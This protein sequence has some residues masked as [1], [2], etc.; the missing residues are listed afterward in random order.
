M[1]V[2]VHS[3]ALQ[4]SSPAPSSLPPS[5]AGTLGTVARGAGTSGATIPGQPMT[6]TESALAALGP[7][8]S[9]AAQPEGHPL[10]LADRAALIERWSAAYGVQPPGRVHTELIRRVLA[11]QEQ[12]DALGQAQ[13]GMTG[14]DPGVGICSDSATNRADQV[15]RVGPLSARAGAGRPVAGVLGASAGRGDRTGTAPAPSSSTST[16]SP[17]RLPAPAGQAAP[18][19]PGTRLLREWQGHTFEVLVSLDGFVYDGHTYR[20]LSA[21]ARA[22]TGTPWSGPAFFG[23]KR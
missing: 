12:V 14:V 10:A 11:W 19:K 1:T 3:S 15:D 21:I 9:A 8:S 7:A 20:S 2:L 6:A 5:W 18:L 17:A 23:L 13:S 16:R 4:P 22:I